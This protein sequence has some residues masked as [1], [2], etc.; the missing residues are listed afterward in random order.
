MA[1][2]FFEKLENRRSTQSLFS[3]YST[4][5]S[6]FNM[7]QAA[8]MPQWS[9]YYG[10]MPTSL[11]S[12]TAVPSA[13]TVPSTTTVQSTGSFPLSG[14]SYP[15]LQGSSSP[16]N[17][18]SLWNNPIT[19]S[20]ASSSLANSS[21]IMGKSASNFLAPLRNIFGG[22]FDAS[23]WP[24]YPAPVGNLPKSSATPPAQISYF[25]QPYQPPSGQM[26]L[27]YGVSSSLLPAPSTSWLPSRL[28]PVSSYKSSPAYPV[29]SYIP[30]VSS[31]SA[32]YSA[33][34]PNSYYAPYSTQGSSGLSFY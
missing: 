4:S 10:L 2:I 21:S 28:P 9:G 29:S 26:S 8:A 18:T 19:S 34:L 30:P 25:P 7:P 5:A 20:A 31:S 17:S 22:F 33:N 14:W 11:L 15:Y 32:Y 27:Y 6:S 23:S 12:N 13:T 1:H 24:A 16:P 3:G